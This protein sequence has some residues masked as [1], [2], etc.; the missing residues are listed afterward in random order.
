MS[1]S[2]WLPHCLTLLGCGVSPSPYSAS[3]EKAVT[4]Q[5]VMESGTVLL[6]VA[7][8]SD[9]RAARGRS[10]KPHGGV[11]PRVLDQEENK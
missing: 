2:G 1:H 11:V 6:M 4:T 9:L 10:L 3:T 5:D 7:R 8:P